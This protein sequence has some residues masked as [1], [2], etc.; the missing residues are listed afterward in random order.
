MDADI[1]CRIYQ[2]CWRFFPLWSLGINVHITVGV[3]LASRHKV[4]A[5]R[6][7]L[8]FLPFLPLLALLLDLPTLFW[9]AEI[10]P[11]VWGPWP[12]CNSNRVAEEIFLVF[13]LMCFFIIMATAFMLTFHLC[14]SAPNVVMKRVASHCAGFILVF[15]LS[16]SLKVL[17][18]GKDALGIKRT[19]WLEWTADLL[20]SSRGIM[21]F[22][23]FVHVVIRVSR[24]PVNVI[25]PE[26]ADSSQDSFNVMFVRESETHE[27]A[28]TESLDSFRGSAEFLLVQEYSL[29]TSVL[30]AERSSP[31]ISEVD[32]QNSSS[33][34]P[35]AQTY[36]QM[37]HS[38]L[39]S[40]LSGHSA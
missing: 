24:R 28:V 31:G 35:R 8:K 21:E 36:P 25:S 37:T 11:R 38:M 34:P 18:Y 23:A 17:E 29:P 40:Q 19:L 30:F 39:P 20:V 1:P 5:L 12:D 2:A 26:S 10:I 32:L 16:W 7:S 13:V 6:A 22:L 27:F 4:Q 15:I 33:L 9:K 14:S 3:Y